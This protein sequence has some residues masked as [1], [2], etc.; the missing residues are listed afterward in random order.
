[1]VFGHQVGSLTTSC[2]GNM[3]MNDNTT[4]ADSLPNG[5]K[6]LIWRI[7]GQGA[8]PLNKSSAYELIR[9]V[10][11]KRACSVDR[12]VDLDGV[13]SDIRGWFESHG[14]R[15]RLRPDMRE[16]VAT[17]ILE[18]I[19]S[20]REKNA[21]WAVG[22][23]DDVDLAAELIRRHWS[24]EEIDSF[25]EDTLTALAEVCVRDDVVDAS[26]CAGFG[27]QGSMSAY[28]AK[29]DL[30]RPGK[31]ETFSHL[32]HHGFELVC[33]GLHPA[34][35]NL[36]ELVVELRPEQFP[37]LIEMVD[38]PVMQA[39]AA[40]RMIGAASRVDHRST[41]NW[42]T[43]DSCKA[44][45]GLAIL[46]TLNTVNRLDEELRYVDGLDTDQHH[47]STEL[48]PP[49]DDLDAAAADLLTGLVNKLAGLEPLTCARWIGE[50]LSHTPYVLPVRD[51]HEIGSRNEQF[52]TAC[53]ELLLRLVQ[54]SWS[55]GLLDA[56]RA[57]LRLSPRITWTRYLAEV[58]WELREVDAVRAV[59]IARVTLEEHER[60]VAEQTDRL[61]VRCNDYDYR[62]WLR[63]LGLALALSCEKLKLLQW[64]SV[65]CEA[66][67]LSVWDA[68]E[69]PEVFSAADRAAQHWLLVALHAL[70]GLK[71]LGRTIDSSEV[72]AF[73]E[74]IWAH[75]HFVEQYFLSRFEASV[76]VE[77]AARY[78]AEFGEPSDEWLLEQ[79]R[80]HRVGPCALWALIDQRKS[81]SNHEK[82]GENGHYD[83]MMTKE[84]VRI[85]SNRFNG[86]GRFGLHELRF[87]GLLW[88]VL[89]A[90]SEAEQTALAIV[91][92]PLTERDRG[93]KIF[94]LKLFALIASKGEVPPAHRDY[95][96]S[97]YDQ[98]W[99]AY[100]PTQEHED[101]KQICELLEGTGMGPKQIRPP[102]T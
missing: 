19:R 51:E 78:A 62:Q 50:L 56:L 39:R 43:K 87:W 17:L 100:T 13:V 41:L 81:K 72:R 18:G 14:G 58:A 68:E 48:R 93:L 53:T 20:E 91:A 3:L 74:K 61:Y 66:L 88:F 82:G 4:P 21:V 92:F 1:M 10:M 83:E 64:V 44:L 94:A 42:I 25:V 97:L 55:D 75:G 23:I 101:R 96:E 31:L 15:P 9:P 29:R 16:P 90:V 52:E 95:I 37:R 57:G 89:G 86:G 34:I 80:D 77:L 85:A 79:A 67:P 11:K 65:H 36:L 12:T 6:A 7:F 28:V 76:V 46:H 70:P 49:E 5:A 47:W 84:L 24:C 59:E 98:L 27:V 2:S 60:H 69:R 102:I 22:S 30:E 26:R 73:A 32:D 40:Y 35:G 99:S 33:H 45:I 8:S 71:E 54:C 63:G 38:H